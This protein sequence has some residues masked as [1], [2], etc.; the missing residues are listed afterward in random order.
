[1]SLRRTPLLAALAVLLSACAGTGVATTSTAV[2]TT[3]TPTTTTA[4]TTST[5]SST[6]TTSTTTTATTAPPVLAP[7][8]GLPLA[9][10]ALIERRVI[11]V[12]V[13]NHPDARPQSGLQDADAVI[14]IIVEG[15]I[16]RFIAL[17]GQSDSDYVGPVRSVRPTDSSLLPALGAP[18]VCAGGTGWVVS[19]ANSRGVHLI[20]EPSD[21]LFRISPRVA[22]HNLYGNTETLRQ[23]A[24]DRGYPDTIRGPLYAV[25]PWEEPTAEATDITFDWAPWH[26]VTWKYVDDHYLRTDA[27]RQQNGVD[28]NG[29]QGALA[30]DVLVVLAGRQ[31][32]ALDAQGQI[33]TLPAIETVGAGTLLIFA[34]GKVLQG[35]WR[36]DGIDQPYQLFDAEG[37]P[38][39]VPPGIPWISIFPLQRSVTWS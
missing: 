37:N 5:T 14:E 13:D 6:T 30:F 23:T 31:Y 10:Q 24:D 39:V 2:P 38:T 3:T 27:G 25:G 33:S 26:S 7:L 11:A 29:N 12:K 16:T 36:R 9:D 20:V 18:L 17:F 4:P 34:H 15:G 21:G 35:T 22:P 1:M 28:E 19:L 8:N 32:W